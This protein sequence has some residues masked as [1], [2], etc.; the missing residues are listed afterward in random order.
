MTA[1]QHLLKLWDPIVCTSR[2]SHWTWLYICTQDMIQMTS[3]EFW[4]EYSVLFTF[5]SLIRFEI[6][7]HSNIKIIY[8]V[9]HDFNQ[10]KILLS[11]MS[12]CE[13]KKK[14]YW[15]MVDLQCCVNFYYTAKW[16]SY[17]HISTV[18]LI[19]FSIMFYPRILCVV[20]YAMQ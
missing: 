10:S 18:S 17:K 6:S 16:L 13:L 19:L 11:H 3:P 9:S 8:T 4:S 2:V 5:K 7:F 1:F 14:N 12:G 20:T 15:S